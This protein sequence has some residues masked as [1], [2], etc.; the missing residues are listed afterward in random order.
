MFANIKNKF[1]NFS[2]KPFRQFQEEAIRFIQESTKPI[3]VIQAPTGAGKSL[4]GMCAGAAAG[5]FTYLVSSKQLQSQLHHDY[6]EV[7]VMKGRNNFS[8]LWRPGH[9][10]DD[11]INSQITRCPHKAMCSY[12]VQKNRVIQAKWRLLNYHY[13]LYE[14]NYVGRFSG[15]PILICDEGDLLEGLLANF[16][17]LRVPG[18]LIEKLQISP[19]R[20]KTAEARHGIESW[21]DWAENEAGAKVYQRLSAIRQM[22]KSINNSSS[23]NLSRLKRE[24]K[25]L[26]T[27]DNRLRIFTQNVNEDWLFEEK[28]GA[29]IFRPTWIPDELAQ[30]FFFQHAERFVL[31]SAT[32]PP[33]NILGKLL[34]RP[35]GDFDYFEVPSTFPVENRRVWLNPVANLTHKTFDEEVEKTLG[36]ILEVASDHLGEK[37]IIHT[38]SY[39]L[40]NTIMDQGLDRFITHN[41]DTREE[42]IELFKKSDQPLILVSPSAERGLDLPDDLCGFIIWAKAPFLYLGD[43]LVSRRVYGS[44][45]GKLWYR[46]HC[47]QTIVQGCGRGVRHQG[48]KCVVYI[49]D[50]Q[51]HRLILDNRFLFPDYFMEAVDIL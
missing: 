5:E 24:E 9:T 19:P 23:P 14:S 31:M 39:K 29:Y 2:G 18:R 44:Q 30:Q 45:T 4:I 41:G 51:I 40:A 38:V 37:G 1:K 42:I 3:C 32:F 12:E 35:P 20:F 47:A 10:C 48:D 36:G 6:P 17:S 34:G 11:C 27:I 13:Y 33:V 7:E 43:K 21:V 46:S 50:Q 26:E 25:Q 15:S 8:C 49:L 28:S 22:L 16:V